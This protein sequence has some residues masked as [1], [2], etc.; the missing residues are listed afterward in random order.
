LVAC[1]LASE[2]SALATGTSSAVSSRPSSAIEDA[3][4]HLRAADLA[5]RTSN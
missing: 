4:N 5:R 1:E 2:R 3:T